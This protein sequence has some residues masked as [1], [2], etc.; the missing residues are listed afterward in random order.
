[1]DFFKR[2]QTLIKLVLSGGRTGAA[3]TATQMVVI[4]VVALIAASFAG[5]YYSGNGGKGKTYTDPRISGQWVDH[6][7]RWGS[8]CGEPA[9]TAWCKLSPEGWTRSTD[10]N[11]AYIG[12]NESTLI[13]GENKTCTGTCGRF[14]KITCDK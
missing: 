5:Y 11:W 10:S 9:A 1:M 14:T 7:Y 12:D 13:L 6:C 3:L 2:L 4:G 8:E